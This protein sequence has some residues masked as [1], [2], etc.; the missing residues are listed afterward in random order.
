LCF[1]KRNAILG[2][3][4][5]YKGIKPLY[6]KISHQENTAKGQENKLCISAADLDYLLIN[7]LPKLQILLFLVFKKR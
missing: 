6:N 7:I 3:V 5:Q 4:K 1:V 2:I